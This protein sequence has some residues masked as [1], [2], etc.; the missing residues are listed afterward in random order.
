VRVSHNTPSV[1][2]ALTVDVE[3]YFMV[4][5]FEP[6]V[7]KARWP[8]LPSRVVPNTDKVLG[9]LSEA[10]VRATFFTLGWV[11]E[12]FPALVRRIA[13]AG[14]EVACHGQSH[15]LL[16]RQT[17]AEFR[18]DV[19]RARAALEDAAGAPVAGY[20]APSFSLVPD[21]LWA[22]DVLA[23]EGF[24]YDASLLPARHARGGMPGGRRGPFLWRNGLAELPMSV[25]NAVGAAWPFS[26][27]GY[28]RLLPLA[29]VAWGVR[30]CHRAGLPAVAY[31]HPWEL[32]PDQPRLPAPPLDRFRHYVNLRRTEPKLRALLRRFSWGTARRVLEG[33][34]GPLGRPAAA[35]VAP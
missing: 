12:R 27:G 19:R 15:R 35:P 4:S 3:D 23:E 17:P 7:P 32:D 14:H 5:A 29:A 13:G 31:L 6:F 18:L 11:A 9:L 34:L 1:V 8:D 25:L 24:L 2:N 20:R 26:G 16:Y 28:L 22:V 10:G 33:S 21:T 30:A